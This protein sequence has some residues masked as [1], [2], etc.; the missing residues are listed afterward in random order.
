M[1]GDEQTV[2]LLGRIGDGDEGAWRELYDLYHDEL[3]F[4][5]RLQLGARLRAV[6]ESEDVFQSVALEAFRELPKLDYRGKGCVSA[7]LRQ[8]VRNKIRTRAAF[9]AAR[10]RSAPTVPLTEGSEPVSAEPPRY[11]DRER[12]ESLEAC[13][14]SL[15]AGMRDA[16]LLRRFQG[17]SNAEAAASTG[18]SEDAMRKLYSRA[19]TRLGQLMTERGRA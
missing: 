2:E 7:F 1:P 4:S 18:R 14:R 9:F 15:P 5:I 19:I 16:V 17:L 8:L 12:F 6:L 13:M 3:L 11:R 10:K